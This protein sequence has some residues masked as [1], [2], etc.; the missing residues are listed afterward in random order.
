MRK[1]VRDG[2]EDTYG[3]LDYQEEL[4][5][6]M[7]YIDAFCETNGIDYCLMA[8]SALG[9]ERH[10]GFI[11]WDDDIDIAMPRKD[12]MRFLKISEKSLPDNCSVHSIHSAFFSLIPIFL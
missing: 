5:K 8:G 11:P 3:I 4:L 12:Y 9:A 10:Q 6:I 2:L 1:Y 7:V